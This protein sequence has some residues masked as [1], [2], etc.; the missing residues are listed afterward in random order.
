M[1]RTPPWGEPVNWYDVW[2]SYTP[3]NE[4]KNSAR[5]HLLVLFYCSLGH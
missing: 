3:Y 2:T 5:A 4:I 1:G